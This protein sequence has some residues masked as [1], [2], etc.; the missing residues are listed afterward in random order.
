MKQIPLSQGKF[1][2]VDDEDYEFLMQWKWCAHKEYNTYYA[3]RGRR[4]LEKTGATKIKMHRQI[5]GITDPKILV[6]HI[7]HNGLNNQRSN[8]RQCTHHQNLMNSGRVSGVS[9]F[10]GVWWDKARS[11]WEAGLRMKYIKKYLGRFDSETDAAIAY[12]KAA[13]EHFGEF[14]FLNEVA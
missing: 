9:K 14:A 11:K 6:D 10:R 13:K 8:I 1:A 5:L 2:L 3:I 12:N 4:A 7:D